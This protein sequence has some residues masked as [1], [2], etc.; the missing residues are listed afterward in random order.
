MRG[1]PDVGLIKARNEV[2]PCG[3]GFKGV[4]V[5]VGQGRWETPVAPS[6]AAAQLLLDT[7]NSMLTPPSKPDSP[8]LTAIVAKHAADKE[9]KR[10]LGHGLFDTALA[11]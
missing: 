6:K 7:L 10:Q 9:I 5:I 11:S 2:E 4:R 1:A 3:E 8:V